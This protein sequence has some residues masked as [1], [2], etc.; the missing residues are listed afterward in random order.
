MRVP[1]SPAPSEPASAPLT[2]DAISLGFVDVVSYDGT[3]IRAWTND[4]DGRLDSPTVLLCN[5][6]GTSPYMW[7]SLL[8]P[9]A[10]VRVVSWY[11]RGVGGSGRPADLDGL[12]VEQFVEDALAV[13]D[14]FDVSRCVVAGWSIGVNTAFELAIRHPD[15]VSALFAMAGVPGDTFATMLQ[16]LLV[17]RPAARALT[18]N[19]SRLLSRFGGLVTPVST[20]VPI[21]PKAVAVLT[22]TGFLMP[23][24]EP[25]LAA[26][27][28]RE[29]LATP[30]DW[31]FRLALASSRHR[32]IRLSRITVPVML[33]A[34]RYDV[35]AGAKDMRTAADRLDD[36]I[37][38]ELPTS[39][40]LGLER[41]TLLHDL[42]RD[43]AAAHTPR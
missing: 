31:F 25:Q 19:F 8:A 26:L 24:P 35:L 4:P 15:R 28:V 30:M 37:Y 14:H 7:P 1:L 34:G 6:L 23:T 41:P 38:V 11:H 13:L 2:P 39:H 20:R 40:F 29:F 36:A 16:P 21:G 33:V 10:E 12:G 32:R 42:L 9:D 3:T 5:G 22:H 43:F 27:A 18:I 17:P